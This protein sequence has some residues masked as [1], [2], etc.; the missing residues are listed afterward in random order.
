MCKNCLQWNHGECSFEFI[1]LVIVILY[2]LIKQSYQCNQQNR[3]ML[4]TRWYMSLTT[5]Y[6]IERRSC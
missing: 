3:N 5:I 6:V 1:S 4:R 2:S